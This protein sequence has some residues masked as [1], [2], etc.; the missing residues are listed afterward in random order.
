MAHPA[1]AGKS[2]FKK[3]KQPVPVR[4]TGKDWA[5]QIRKACEAT[6]LFWSGTTVCWMD[7]TVVVFYAMFTA[8]LPQ[9]TCNSLNGLTFCRRQQP[10]HQGGAVIA[11]RAAMRGERAGGHQSSSREG[12]TQVGWGAGEL[13]QQVAHNRRL[14]SR[15][16]WQLELRKTGCKPGLST[17]D[18]AAAA[19]GSGQRFKQ[20]AC[21]PLLPHT[22]QALFLKTADSV[23]LPV[24]Q[25]L[26]DA[27]QK[28]ES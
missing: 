8:P 27:A 5:A 10:D 14:H 22:M 2:F 28:I 18:Q 12:S 7:G 9:L 24:Y 1:P 11:E 17:C 20:L 19:D 21:C 16:R 26:P 15:C 6:Y 23:A 13:Q 4:L 25:V 3:K